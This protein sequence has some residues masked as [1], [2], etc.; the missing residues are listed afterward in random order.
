M[1]IR[2]SINAEYMGLKKNKEVQEA[3]H[4]T[5]NCS[6]KTGCR[7]IKVRNIHHLLNQ[8]SAEEH[9]FKVHNQPVPPKSSKPVVISLTSDPPKEPTPV[10]FSLQKAEEGEEKAEEPK[11]MSHN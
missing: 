11:A 10:R 3:A 8:E 6:I 7:N 9:N 4:I 2:D 5:A 1:C